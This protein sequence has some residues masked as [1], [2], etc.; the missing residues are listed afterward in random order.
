MG[1]RLRKARSICC[2]DSP[3]SLYRAP[4]AIF[5]WYMPDFTSLSFNVCVSEHLISVFPWVRIWKHECRSEFLY[6]RLLARLL[7]WSSKIWWSDLF[8][9]VFDQFVHYEAVRGTWF[10]NENWKFKF[11]FCMICYAIRVYRNTM[12]IQFS[13][14]L[15][16][17]LS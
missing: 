17:D 3:R 15:G 11:S 8:L 10:Q 14:C 16:W 4:H 9:S 6:W 1:K 2:C 5:S 12:M 7:F 13:W